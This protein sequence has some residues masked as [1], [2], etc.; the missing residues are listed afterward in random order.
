M[1]G[2]ACARG[3]RL[4]IQMLNNHLPVWAGAPCDPIPHLRLVFQMRRG[5]AYRRSSARGLGVEGAGSALLEPLGT[6][7]T[8]MGHRFHALQ[9]PSWAL[10]MNT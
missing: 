10:V 1:T 9:Q 5:G 2:T 3:G 7:F 4:G 6:L 8:L